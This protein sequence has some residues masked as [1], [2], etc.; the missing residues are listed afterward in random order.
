MEDGNI[1][2]VDLAAV[3]ASDGDGTDSTESA[4]SSQLRSNAVWRVN[5][6]ESLPPKPFSVIDLTSPARP[7]GPVYLGPNPRPVKTNGSRSQGSPIA[8][9]AASPTPRPQIDHQIRLLPAEIRAP[10]PQ[11]GQMEFT[12]H[13]TKTLKKMTN[14]EAP[15]LK[16]FR[17]AFVSRDIQVL[18][19][20]YWQFWIKIAEESIVKES[21]QPPR[22]TLK[23]L[24][25][26]ARKERGKAA[27]VRE[28]KTPVHALW[29][30]CEFLQFWKNVT[31]V[32]E[33]DQG[34]HMGRDARTHLDVVFG[35]I[36]SAD[37]EIWGMDEKGAG[38][39]TRGLEFGIRLRQD[40]W[41]GLVWWKIDMD[42]GGNWNGRGQ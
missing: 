31:L 13:L 18:E 38:G 2:G 29:T 41:N 25:S 42:F 34:I 9:L 32:I 15:L 12:T 30:E 39:G 37:G 19:R 16:H 26:T 35:V 20:G 22:A 3:Q 6:H 8:S 27:G 40:A 24:G 17:P 10:N 21:R 4:S 36:R 1:E 11:G 23:L 28:L 14:G 5:T 7:N 33:S